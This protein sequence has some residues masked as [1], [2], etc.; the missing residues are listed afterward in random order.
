LGKEVYPGKEWQAG[1]KIRGVQIASRELWSR[2]K[3]G[4]V[5]MIPGGVTVCR[6]DGLKNAETVSTHKSLIPSPVIPDIII[7]KIQYH[8]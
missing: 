8:R 1:V 7:F 3:P 4:P 2:V 5:E 6:M